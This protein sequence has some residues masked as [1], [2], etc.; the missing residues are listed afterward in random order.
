MKNQR[1]LFSYI[2]LG[3]IAIALGTYFRLFPILFYTSQDSNEK[4]TLIVLSNLKTQIT[5]KIE[6]SSPP[7]NAHDKAFLID[8]TFKELIHKE[9]H[10]VRG[11]IDSLSIKMGEKL[12][13]QP[14]RLPYLLESDPFLFYNLTENILQTGKISDTLKGSKYLNKMMLAPDG[15]WEPFSLHPY[16][17]YLLYYIAKAVSPS[18]S[19][20]EAVG[21]TP[22]VLSALTL[23]PFL[24]ICYQ[25]RCL[26]FISFTG[27]V[28]LLL[29]PIF[30]KRSTYGWYD[31]DPY[32]VLFP[33]C[34]L[35]C[36]FYGLA[37]LRTLKR[38]VAWGAASV[39]FIMLYALFWQGWMFILGILFISLLFILIYHFLFIKETTL[40]LPLI[41]HFGLIGTGTFLAIGLIFG[42]AEFLALI[43]EGWHAL[44]NFMTPQLSAWPD[45]YISVGELHKASLKFIIEIMGGPFFCAISLFGLITSTIRALK[46]KDVLAQLPIIV[47]SVFFIST[48][49]MTLGAQRFAIL[50]LTPS[51]ILFTLGLQNIFEGLEGWRKR[52]MGSWSPMASEI[53]LAGLM[54]GT[55]ILP[56]LNIQKSIKT[57]LTPI[58][59]ET[60]EKA[61]TKIQEQTPPDSI[62]NAWWP[63]GHFIKAIAHRRVTFDGATINYPQAYWIANVFLS[64][65]EEEALGILRMLNNSA[66]QAADYLQSIGFDLPTTVLILKEITKTDEA[67]ARILLNKFTQ[68]NAQINHLLS[69]THRQPPPSYLLIYNE[70]VENNLQL[71]FFGNWDFKKVSEINKSS[72]LLA[73]VP[74]HNTDDYIKFLWNLVGGAY[75]YSGILNQISQTERNILFENN[76]RINLDSKECHVDSKQY[77]QGIP[78]SIFYLEDGKVLEKK[79]NNAGLNFSVLL[80]ADGRHYSTVLLDRRLAQSLLIRLYFFKGIGLKYFEPFEEE[81]DLTQ[82]THI[83][84]FEINWKEFL[85][86]SGRN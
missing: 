46:Q 79:F 61:L 28:F 81:T 19:L 45:I 8:K 68:N 14:K 49:I 7:L 18:I 60:W 80:L 33:L 41:I 74:K 35:V 83:Q 58:F 69:L 67:Q 55:I 25:L 23:I 36:L 47:I 72:Q 70:F 12:S 5:Q 6:T 1:H 53:I 4:A 22:L 30:I 63:P 85:R 24:I 3:L 9:G 64:K 15:H 56:I 51:A 76:V 48:L 16:I 44:T 21:F 73:Q 84:I 54:I 62:V 34:I 13:S 38:S 39:F 37:N 78:Y 27:A 26:L 65:T 11:L 57:L 29:A 10:R 2:L 43:Q 17:G 86:T 71:P 59:N 20:M 82:R 40:S 52:F 50:L 77:G 66:N 31:N 75:R 32:S 42:P